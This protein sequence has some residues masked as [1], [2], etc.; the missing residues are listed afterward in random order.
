[1]PRRAVE[2]YHSRR[3]CRPFPCQ[4]RLDSLWFPPVWCKPQNLY[5]GLLFN[6][7]RVHLKHYKHLH[8]KTSHPFIHVL[9]I[10]T[11]FAVSMPEFS[12]NS[13]HFSLLFSSHSLLYS[14][15][16][17][18]SDNSGAQVVHRINSCMV[19]ALSKSKTQHRRRLEPSVPSSI[20]A[21]R[22]WAQ[23]REG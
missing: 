14:L 16:S 9:L 22:R 5:S 20:G 10:V 13:S 7:Y 11:H 3:R 12:S 23:S 4:P 21:T 15:H 8:H 6:K 18:L 17:L 19:L 1:M 2:Q